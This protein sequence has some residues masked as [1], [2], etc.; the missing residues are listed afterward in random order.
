MKRIPN[1]LV[2][3]TNNMYPMLQSMKKKIVDFY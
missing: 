1:I 3:L 2:S